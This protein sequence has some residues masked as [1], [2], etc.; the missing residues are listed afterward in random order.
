[1][2]A[3]AK[4]LQTSTDQVVQGYDLDLNDPDDLAFFTCISARTDG[5]EFLLNLN[6]NRSATSNAATLGE[7]KRCVGALLMAPDI[8]LQQQSYKITLLCTSWRLNSHVSA[9]SYLLL[10]TLTFFF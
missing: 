8:Y 4:T 5:I 6:H 10:C 7:N 1:M 9:L 3:A 2:G